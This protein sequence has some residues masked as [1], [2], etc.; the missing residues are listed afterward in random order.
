MSQLIYITELINRST[1]LIYFTNGI[2]FL[3]TLTLIL[4]LMNKIDSLSEK[5]NKEESQPTKGE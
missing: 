4:C 3:T 5:L 1:A 2:M